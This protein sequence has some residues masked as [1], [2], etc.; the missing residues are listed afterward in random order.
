MKVFLCIFGDFYVAIPMNSVLS[1]ALHD[2]NSLQN[3]SAMTHNEGIFYRENGNIFVALP[4]LFNLPP[5]N[6]RHNIVLK[7][8][9]AKGDET[10]ENKTVLFIPEVECETD[11]PDDKIFPI[12]KALSSTRFSLMFSGIQFNS[13]QAV[14]DAGSGL[15][16]MM[17][18]EKLI[19]TAQKETPL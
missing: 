15:V 6:I 14:S 8:P 7:D 1:L 10:S 16:L 9:D 4:K 11:I 12:P 18:S 3:V 5:E 17:D 13:R 2:E 19:Q